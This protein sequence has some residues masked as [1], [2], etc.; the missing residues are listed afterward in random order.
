[1]MAP[2]RGSGRWPACTARVPNPAVRSSSKTR[3][4]PILGEQVESKIIPSGEQSESMIDAT[5]NEDRMARGCSPV[6]CLVVDD[7]PRLRHVLAQ[8]LEADGFRVREA[9]DGQEAIAKLEQQPV[10]L[11]LSDVRMPR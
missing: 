10:E 2:A 6:E 5:E 1:M 11:L 3:V 4:M 9:A 7:E 8:M